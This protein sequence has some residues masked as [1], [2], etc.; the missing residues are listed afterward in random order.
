MKRS[1]TILSFIAVLALMLSACNV[2]A[3]SLNLT[4][5]Q[6][7]SQAV[8]NGGAVAQ[9]EPTATTMPQA[10]PGAAQQAQTAPGVN[11]SLAAYQDALVSI[12]TQVNPSVVNIQV[13]INATSSGNGQGVPFPGHPSI[14]QGQQQALG[15]GFVWSKDGYLITN[16]HVVAG[17]DKISVQFSDG[18][19]VPAKLVGA[20][21]DSDLAV[22]KVDVSADRLQPVTLADST[23][24]K[25]GQLAIAIGNPFGLENTMT[26][27]IVSALGRSL[28]AE[29]G[30]QVNGSTYTI[31]DIIQTDAPINPGNS[32]GVLLDSQGQ[33]IGVT[34]AIES[35]SNSSS[36]IGFVIPSVIVG[37][38]VP[39]L[40]K[41]GKFLHPWIGISGTTL[42][43]DLNQQM[44]L[45]SDQRGILIESV[46]PNS[47]AEKAGLKAGSRQA[48]IN[49]IDLNVGGDVITAIDGQ[50]TND[51]DTLV[52][53]LIRS[54]TVGQTVELTI[55][56]NGQ[57]QKVSLALEARPATVNQ[58]QANTAQPS[59]PNQQPSGVYLGVTGIGLTSTIDKLLG[60]PAD[61]QG[62]LFLSVQK[63]SPA[64]KAGIKGGITPIT[65][66]GTAI[67]SGGDILTAV[68]AQVVTQM[69]DLRAIL[70]NSN[71]GDVLTLT[72]VRDGKQMDVKVTLEQRP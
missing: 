41:N 35:S 16:N 55:L 60:L 40:I 56:R 67:M 8:N 18:S 7:Q 12:Y 29:A 58:P 42:D 3:L 64:D 36:G 2:P 63:G 61:Q 33:V 31:P 17:A 4:K 13:M 71:P 48:T 44:N 19:I 23:K 39:E 9:V 53:Y 69:S 57:E 68:D 46:V 32:G 1:L 72:I 65:V 62:I 20:D 54:T 52:T 27:G 70:A 38:V 22:I 15:S 59:A 21:P 24:V 11:A 25:V 28:P 50:P 66:N 34:A 37:K 14:P 51:F 6:Q 5:P 30:S 43:P 10:G 49:G 26:V 45:K 47:P